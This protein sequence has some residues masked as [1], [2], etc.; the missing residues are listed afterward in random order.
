KFTLIALL[1]LLPLILLSGMQTKQ[2]W[3]ELRQLQ[4]E[5]AGL[6]LQQTALQLIGLSESYRDIAA[7]QDGREDTDLQ[8]RL[9]TIQA[10]WLQQHQQ[11]QQQADQK[12]AD[13]NLQAVMQALQEQAEGLF[14]PQGRLGNQALALAHY[15]PLVSNSYA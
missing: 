10:D 13:T 8:Q 1:F 2:L 11:L 14:R 9:Q 4:R 12:L 3:D 5:R 6:E 7:L 15:Q